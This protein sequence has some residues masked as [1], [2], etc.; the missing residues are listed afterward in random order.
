MVRSRGDQGRV[1]YGNRCWKVEGYFRAPG[2][3]VDQHIIPAKQLKLQ[4]RKRWVC[5]RER[6]LCWRLMPDA[7]QRRPLLDFQ[8]P[9]YQCRGHTGWSGVE[10][11]DARLPHDLERFVAGGE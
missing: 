8:I 4:C 7:L 6:S 2:M 1:S 3:T 11:G 9:V 5:I 10:N